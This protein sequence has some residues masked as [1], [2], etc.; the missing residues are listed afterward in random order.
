[1]KWNKIKYILSSLI[2]NNPNNKTKCD[3]VL[4]HFILSIQIYPHAT[5]LMWGKHESSFS[6]NLTNNLKKKKKPYEQH[7]SFLKA[8]KEKK[9]EM[10]LS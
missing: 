7:I 9:Y 4:F 6:N 5:A 3:S 2:L 10:S 1:M 8:E